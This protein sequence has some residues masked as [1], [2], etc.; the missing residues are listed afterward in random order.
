MLKEKTAGVNPLLEKFA[1]TIELAQS[2]EKQV[3]KIYHKFI[4]ASYTPQLAKCL[5]PESTDSGKHLQRISLIRTSLALKSIIIGKLPLAIP[6]LKKA[7][8]VQDLDLI[9]Q[10]LNLQ[11]QKLANYQ[12]LH[13]LAIAMNLQMESEMIGQTI[14]DICNTS[15]WMRQIIKNIIGPLLGQIES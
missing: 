7:S 2:L 10:A 14:T 12:L 4:S 11:H 9:G 8:P 1:Q 13:P 6:K 3:N 5:S 15:T